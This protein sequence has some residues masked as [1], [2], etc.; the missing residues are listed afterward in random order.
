[1]KLAVL[2]RTHIL[3][4]AAERLRAAGHE[5]RLVATC[6]EEEDYE[7]TAADF[8]DFAGRCGAD[9][10]FDSAINSQKR[11]EQLRA[12]NCGAAVSMNWLTIV[13]A[14]ACNSFPLGI[15]NVHAGDLP[16]F[17]G[18]ACPNWA[19]LMGETH[20]G[21]CV[22][23]MEPDKLDSGP[24]LLRDRLPIDDSTYIGD[25]YKWL[26]VRIP[27]LLVEAVEG[28]QQATL[29]PEVQPQDSALALRCY[30]RR[31]E[32]GKIYWHSSAE[33]VW[34]LIRASSRPFAGAFTTLDG[35]PRLTIWRAHPFDHPGAFAAVPGQVM[36]RNGDN[37]VIACGDGAVCITEASL[38][39]HS[40]DREAKRQIL[41]SLRQRLV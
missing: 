30:P 13:G 11:I 19:I 6:R 34:R 2:G 35:G 23:I 9:F 16:R 3:L 20:V 22:H 33:S 32:D 4:S 28:L 17:R 7:A 21:L 27:D 41:K 12:A 15:L 18:N 8:E 29:V 10:F 37:P 26:E 14:E 38:E 39:A 1:M 31:P 24:I 5:I 40:S 36:F 25:V